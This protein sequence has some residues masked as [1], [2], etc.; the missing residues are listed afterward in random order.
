MAADICPFCDVSAPNIRGHDPDCLLSRETFALILGNA[1]ISAS[2]ALLLGHPTAWVND[3]AIDYAFAHLAQKQW[4]H[5]PAA[6]YL[7]QPSV[8]FLVASLQNSSTSTLR[9]LL[10]PTILDHLTNGRV[11]ICT[12][13]DSSARDHHGL[14][15]PDPYRGFTSYP[16]FGGG[17]HWSLLIRAPS[18][19]LPAT[20]TTCWRAQGTYWHLDSR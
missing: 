12:V 2:D 13:N 5:H 9:D 8:S 4:K 17:T 10:G 3:S 20:C 1:K 16:T 6:P 15:V 14:S 19:T 18:D 11:I 7:V